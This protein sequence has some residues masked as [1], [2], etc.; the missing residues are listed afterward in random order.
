MIVYVYTIHIQF[1]NSHEQMIDI[2][3]GMNRVGRKTDNHTMG[4]LNP[5]CR[6]CAFQGKTKCCIYS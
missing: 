3:K 5:A 4:F 2:D 6:D 1:A